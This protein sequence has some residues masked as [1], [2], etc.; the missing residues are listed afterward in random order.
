MTGSET[1]DA[2]VA[3]RPDELAGRDAPGRDASGGAENRFARVVETLPIALVLVAATGRIELVNRRAERM[4]GYDRAELLGK[5]LEFLM[6][7]RG[8]EPIG[9]RKDGS[10]IPLEIDRNPVDIDGEPMVLASIVDITARHEAERE[11]EEQ[12]VELLRSNADLEEFAYLASHDLKAPLRGIANLVQWIGDDTAATANPETLENLKLLRNRVTRLQMLLDG[13]LAYSRVGR[14]HAAVEE[15]DVAVMVDDI[16]AMLAPPPGFSVVREGGMPVIRTHRAP[17]RVVLEN[18]IGN[19]LKHHDHAE[20]RITV[21][22]R[23]VDG[24]VE[25]R[26]GDDGPGISPWFHDRIFM[27][28]E[29]LASR[30]DVESSGI[31]LAVVKKK[32]EGHGGRIHVESAPPVRG[33]TFVFTWKE[34]VA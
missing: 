31:G 18:L 32:V 28:F 21:A 14:K 22:M 8:R 27:I 33:A 34:A 5:S 15:V 4:F 19:A 30:E 29:T 10:E 26:V 9:R 2:G 24:M 17:L 25:F 6:P 3:I 20:G 11:R 12:R 16:V 23:R 13:L 1:A 7:K